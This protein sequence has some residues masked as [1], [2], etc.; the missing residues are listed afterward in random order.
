V[1]SS[2]DR[3]ANLET[4]FLLQRIETFT[5]IVLITSNA[6]DR[7]D[8]AFARR[9]DVVIHFKPPDEW[10]RHE[11]L[12]LHL[13]D[14]QVSADLLQDIACRCMLSGGQLRNV[15]S[16]AMLLALQRGAAPSSTINDLDLHAAL[17]RE[18]RKTG[19]RCPLPPPR[20]AGN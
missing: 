8:R 3:Y 6:A 18:Y 14:A 16:H 11:I 13:P 20:K 15:T 9:M 12:R 1:A 5:G 4:N 19:G 2:N 7:I 17:A 10:T